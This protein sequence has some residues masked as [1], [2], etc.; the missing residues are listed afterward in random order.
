MIQLLYYANTPIRYMPVP[1]LC[2]RVDT[3]GVGVNPSL[4]FK[5]NGPWKFIGALGA[6]EDLNQSFRNAPTLAEASGRL[7]K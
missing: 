1:M 3:S 6:H 7:D 2:R 4:T 5:L